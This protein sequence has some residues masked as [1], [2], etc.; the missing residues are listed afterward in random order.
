H[1][2]PVLARIGIGDRGDL[3]GGDR[4]ARL[5]EQ[6]R[7][8]RALDHAGLGRRRKLWPRQIGLE[9]LVGRDEPAAAVAVEQM[10]P[11]REPEILHARRVLVHNG[12]YITTPCLVMPRESE[13]SSTPFRRG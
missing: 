2:C 9:E 6:R 13:A 5:G 3:A 8:Q 1:Q 4:P 12:A 11:A 10:M 7:M